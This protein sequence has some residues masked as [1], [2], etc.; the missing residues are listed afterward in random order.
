MRAASVFCVAFRVI[1]CCILRN[2]V[3]AFRKGLPN[4][5]GGSKRLKVLRRSHLP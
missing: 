3:V 1:P 2:F 5:K 4:M